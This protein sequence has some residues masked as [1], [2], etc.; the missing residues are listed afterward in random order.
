MPGDIA[1]RTRIGFDARTN[2]LLVV[3]MKVLVGFDHVAAQ[4]AIR[5]CCKVS[6]SELNMIRTTME[7]RYEVQRT[8]LYLLQLVDESLLV[9]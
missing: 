7:L 9:W 8:H 5:E 4:A 3:E 2:S 6:G 1:S